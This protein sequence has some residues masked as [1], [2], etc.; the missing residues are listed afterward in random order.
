M[1]N[2]LMRLALYYLSMSQ[3]R[4]RPPP[5]HGAAPAYQAVP[6]ADPGVLPGL[7]PEQLRLLDQSPF[8]ISAGKACCV[9]G[10]LPSSTPCP[11]RQR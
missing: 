8:T 1:N 7:S 5:H 10:G 3:W 4:A 6:S 2:L 9:E 11:S